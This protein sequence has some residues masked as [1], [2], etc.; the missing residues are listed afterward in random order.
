MQRLFFLP[1]LFLRACL[2]PQSLKESNVLRRIDADYR[3]FFPATA[4]P[5]LSRGAGLLRSRFGLPAVVPADAEEFAFDVDL[6]QRGATAPVALTLVPPAPSDPDA[7]A[8][9]RSAE[10]PCLRLLVVQHER[11]EI[12]LGVARLRLRVKPARTDRRPP[13]GAYD[14]YVSSAVDSPMR[15]R[16]PCLRRGPW[17][18]CASPTCPT[19]TSE[20]GMATSCPSCA[21]SSPTSTSERPTSS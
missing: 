19:F 20:K 11:T 2:R 7:A 12:T 9:A 8:C 6:L 3:Q 1:L 10:S 21:R 18:R 16:A 13:L 5:D 4:D 14:L 17:I 15:A